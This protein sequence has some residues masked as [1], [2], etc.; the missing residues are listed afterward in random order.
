MSN[1]KSYSPEVIDDASASPRTQPR[2]VLGVSPRYWRIGI[3]AALLYGLSIAIVAAVRGRAPASWSSVAI[4]LAGGALIAAMFAFFERKARARLDVGLGVR[5]EDLF[6]T[7]QKRRIAIDRP[8]AAILQDAVDALSEYGAVVERRD[9]VQG[10]IEALT[11]Q[12]W[13]SYGERLTLTVNAAPNAGGACEVVI[14]AAPR[15]ALMKFVTNYGRSW[16]H[17]EALAARLVDGTFPPAIGA[18]RTVMTGGNGCPPTVMEVG[19]WQRLLTA[20]LL[21]AMLLTGLAQPGKGPLIV[22]VAVGGIVVELYAY[23]RFRRHARARRRSDAQ[24]NAE[25]MLN[26]L[27]PALFAPTMLLDLRGDWLNG[28]N[29]AA[30]AVGLMFVSVAVNRVRDRNRVRVQRRELESSREKAELQRQLA[31][32]RLVAL[33]AQIEPHFLF[34]TLASIQYLIRHDADRAGRMTGDLIRYLRLA[35]PRM[36]QST[37]PLGDE[38]DLVRAYLG[39]MQIRMGERLAYEIP[40]VS[41]TLAARQVP[42]MALI[43]LVENSIKHGLERKPEG[44]TIALDAT[45]SDGTLTLSV[46]DTG[47]GFSTAASGTGIGLANIRE[48][49]QT[50]YGERGRLSLEANQPSGVKAIVTFPL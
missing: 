18:D 28:T 10:R 21:Y 11:Y 49:L 38:L 12:N 19:A 40:A 5:D 47:G 13:K 37:A 4:S 8:R 3:G 33:S 36:K 17:V 22:A 35:L 2:L 15:M 44:G 32:A 46:S 16:E 20:A 43:T 9:D 7:F 34:N 50:L 31:E 48:R 1:P 27:W 14:D 45:E 25:A 26:M 42:T 41:E 30:M 29:L 24:E 39:I 23:F 6:A